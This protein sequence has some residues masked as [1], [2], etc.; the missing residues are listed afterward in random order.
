MKI[1]LMESGG[2]SAGISTPGQTLEFSELDEESAQEGRRLAE[3]LMS[4]STS[5]TDENPHARDDVE[6][7][8]RVEERGASR[9]FTMK[10][11]ALTREFAD[12]LSWLKQQLKEKRHD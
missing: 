8:I 3:Q 10:S 4:H 6:F 7:T 9:E 2:W 12:L 5:P 1:S 11:M